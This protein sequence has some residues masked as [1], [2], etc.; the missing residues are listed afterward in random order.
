M[1]KTI[2]SENQTAQIIWLNDAW[3]FQNLLEIQLILKH[4]I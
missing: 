2:L 1:S 4:Y 3:G